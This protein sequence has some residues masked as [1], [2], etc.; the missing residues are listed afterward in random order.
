MFT[1]NSSFMESATNRVCPVVSNRNINVSGVS[2]NYARV[3]IL[4]LEFDIRLR[5]LDFCHD[6]QYLVIVQAATLVFNSGM[7]PVAFARLALA[8][9][10]F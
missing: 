7:F 6:A 10:S 4:G 5:L 8:T 3:V 2:Y 9:F 1:L